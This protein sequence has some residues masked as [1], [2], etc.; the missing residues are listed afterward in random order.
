MVTLARTLCGVPWSAP[1][2]PHACHSH[3]VWAHPPSSR[4]QQTV[5][6]LDTLWCPVPARTLSNIK[7][8][9]THDT[10]TNW[11]S[12]SQL[13]C[14]GLSRSAT[15][16]FQAFRVLCLFSCQPMNETHLH[17][18]IQHPNQYLS[19]KPRY[20]SVLHLFSNFCLVPAPCPT[21]QAPL[22]TASASTR[23]YITLDKQRNLTIV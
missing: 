8:P 23:R 13:H 5:E 4:I 20:V 15:G 3:G 18:A 21:A 11:N 16:G 22:T 14:V 6:K 7:S 1:R 12:V 2:P 9:E 10:P 19:M 17:N